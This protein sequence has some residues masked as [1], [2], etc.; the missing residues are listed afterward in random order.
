MPPDSPANAVARR[1]ALLDELDAYHEQLVQAAQ[2][3]DDESLDKLVAARQTIIEELGAA[4]QQAPIPTEIG[5]KLAQRE[6][7]LQAI[8]NREFDQ[9][10]NAMGQAARRGK[11][12]L[13]Y[14]RS[15]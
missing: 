3:G 10:R 11:A 2:S 6:A 12:A 7:E 13:R 5:E 8:L 1:D 9:A 14:R 15:R 4:A